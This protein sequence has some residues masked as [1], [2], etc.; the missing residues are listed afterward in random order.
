[1]GTYEKNTVADQQ[2][3][4]ADGAMLCTRIE[5]EDNGA[6]MDGGVSRSS[7]PFFGPSP[8]IRRSV[9]VCRQYMASCTASRSDRMRERRRK[10]LCGVLAIRSRSCRLSDCGREPKVVKGWR[11]DPDR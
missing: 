1:M 2:V 11:E 6:G 10:D 9:W 8:S 5:V 7:I 4:G 3:D